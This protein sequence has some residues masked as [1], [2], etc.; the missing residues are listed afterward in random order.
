MILI[1]IVAFILVGYIVFLIPFSEAAELSLG[2]I[3]GLQ[4]VII[5]IGISVLS[6]I[7]RIGKNDDKS[8]ES[9]QENS[10]AS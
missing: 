10:D 8:K 6:K 2:I 4:A 5:V 1:S 7:S 9:Q 3:A